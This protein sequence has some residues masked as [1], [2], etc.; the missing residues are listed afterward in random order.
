[1][2][3]PLVKIKMADEEKSLFKKKKRKKKKK[4]KKTYLGVEHGFGCGLT[5][6]L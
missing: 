4:E 2:K 3:H 6:G 5:H 1:M